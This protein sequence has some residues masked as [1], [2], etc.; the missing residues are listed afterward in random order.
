MT[1]KL[2]SNLAAFLSSLP[3]NLE[4]NILRGGLKAGAEVIA[5]GAREGCRS[6]EVRATI[7]T[8]SRAE[9]GLVTAKVQTKGPG[10]YKA[11]WLEN[12][13]DPHYI[14]VD[15]EQSG[16]RTVRKVNRLAQKG[17][18]VINGVPVGDTVHHPGARP[19]PF[20]R[21]ALDQREQ[22]AIDAI[23]GYINRRLTKE[24][25]AAPAPPEDPEE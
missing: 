12:G 20:M 16:G 11:P 25:L 22:Q 13:T 10:A 7:G 23:G 21:P 15:P 5:D 4:R 2:T 18:L 24:G 6:A 9:P 8:T 19:Y 3:G 14:S 17:T 1:A